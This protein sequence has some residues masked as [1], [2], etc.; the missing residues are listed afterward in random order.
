MSDSTEAYRSFEGGFDPFAAEADRFEDDGGDQVPR[1]YDYN[2]NPISVPRDDDR[3]APVRIAELLDRLCAQ[4][5]T[6]EGILA[7][8]VE[9][10]SYDEV[11]DVVARLQEGNASVF[12]AGRLCSLLERAGALERVDAQGAPFGSEAPVERVE[13]ESGE[14]YLQPSGSRAVYWLA[15]EA[16]LAAVPED[17]STAQLSALLEA[18]EVYLPIYRGVLEMASAQGGVK[19]PKLMAAFDDDP[20]LQH[21]RRSCTLFVERLHDVD[22]L[23]WRGAW[24]TT[25][26]GAKALQ[27]IDAVLGNPSQTD[28]GR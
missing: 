28:E 20:L 1:R 24:F 17:D 13:G 12:D 4:R 11:C 8:C 14:A 16:G 7:A 2:P 5:K 6:C 27:D 9:P 22:A 25:D 21:P 26:L 10:R 3:P 19:A 23:E 15:T 18:D